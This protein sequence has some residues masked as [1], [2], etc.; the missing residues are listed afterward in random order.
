[1]SM[2]NIGSSALLAAQTALA[3]TSH[4]ISNVNTA[5]YSRQ[6]TDQGTQ[7][8]N[9]EGGYYIGNG[10][11]ITG[12]DRIFNQFLI[13]QLRTYTSAESQ[14]DGFLTF[15]KQVD[16]LLGTSSLS[17]NGGL[18]AFFNSV[19]EVANDPTSI[20]ARQ[21][22]LTQG[23]LLANRFNTMDS[24]LSE[25]DR[26][27]DNTI[28]VS[29]NDIN[30]LSQGIVDL[31]KSISE[32]LAAGYQPNDL[33]DKRDK[34]INDLSELVSVNVVEQ[35]NGSVNV[36][37]GNGQGL[38][39]GNTRTLLSAIPDNSTNPPRTAIGFGPTQI[40]VTQQI[41]GGEIGGALLARTSIVDTTRA[42]L[43]VLAEAVVTA[44]NDVHDN[45]IDLNGNAGIDFFDATG[46]TAGTMRMTITDPRLIAASSTTNT[47]VGNNE[48]ALAMA[49]L[50]TDKTTVVLD[51][52][53]PVISR[54]FNEQYGSIVSQVATRTNQASVTQQ[55]QAGLVSQIRQRAESVSGVNLDEEAAN[56]I[57]FQQ[58]YQA[59]SQIITVSNTVFNSLINAL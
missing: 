30:V 1:M 3:T 16:D 53:P 14:Q 18:E 50:Q 27:I 41:T 31:N 32:S 48:N 10:V 36:F 24:Q 51:P 17:I 39:V 49:A 55:T 26:Q 58:A 34:L 45:G 2:L 43:D 57:K 54:S 5:G 44:F 25:L 12:V 19:Q 21:V 37:I 42:E 40:N 11:G 8:A 33:L 47:G 52:G 13:N 35:A 22:M 4:N 59:A 7:P 28:S 29:I 15:S 46:I 9:F 6:R 56:L 20:A 23:E 38:V